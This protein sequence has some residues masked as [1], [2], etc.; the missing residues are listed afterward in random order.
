VRLGNEG[1]DPVRH[2]A[3]RIEI[4]VRQ[5]ARPADVLQILDK[6][7]VGGLCWHETFSPLSECCPTLFVVG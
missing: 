7:Q 1:V 5:L 2:D 3:E 4:A 6:E